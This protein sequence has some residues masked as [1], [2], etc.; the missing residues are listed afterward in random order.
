MKD[1]SSSTYSMYCW[2]KYGSIMMGNEKKLD[3][4]GNKSKAIKIFGYRERSQNWIY[5]MAWTKSKFY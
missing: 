1:V 3:G 4:D 5:V 2:V